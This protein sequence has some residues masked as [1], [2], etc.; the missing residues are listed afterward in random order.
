MGLG[1]NFCS[2]SRVATRMDRHVLSPGMLLLT[3]KSVGYVM[4]KD[5]APFPATAVS[6]SLHQHS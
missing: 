6:L 5:A 3:L 4:S 1:P 2:V